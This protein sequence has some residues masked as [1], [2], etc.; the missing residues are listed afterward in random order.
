MAWYNGHPDYRDY[1]FDLS[2]ERVAVSGVGNLAVDVARIFARTPEE[3]GATDIADYALTAL[4]EC[5]VREIYILGR[6]GPAQAAFTNAELK[7]LG[8]L[9]GADFLIP[10]E[11]AAL[12]DLSRRQVDESDDRATRKKVELIQELAGRSL[13]GKPK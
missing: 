5:K 13:T 12:D 7:E 8:Q 2:A 4:R 3:L 9:E 11:D 6:R 1:Q 10:A